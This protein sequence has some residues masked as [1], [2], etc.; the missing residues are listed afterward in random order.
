MLVLIFGSCMSIGAFAESFD[1][2]TFSDIHVNTSTGSKICKTDKICLEKCGKNKKSAQCK[3]CTTCTTATRHIMEINPKGSTRNAGKEHQ[4]DLDKQTWTYFQKLIQDK[5]RTEMP[6]SRFSVV[7]GDLAGHTAYTDKRKEYLVEGFKGL[8][9]LGLPASIFVVGNNDSLDA[10]YG[11][12]RNTYEQTKAAGWA[13]PYLSTGKQC[14]SSPD[15][16][17]CIVEEDSSDYTGYFVTKIAPDLKLI[18]I[19]SV[20]LTSEESKIHHNQGDQATL[21]WLD[22]KVK[23]MGPNETALLAMHI[24]PPRTFLSHNKTKFEKTLAQNSGKIIGIFAGHSHMGNVNSYVITEKGSKKKHIIPIINTPG[25]CSFYGNAP[26]F[27]HVTMTRKNPESPWAIK[28]FS[29]WSIMEDKNGKQRP[30]NLK[31]SKYFSFNASHCPNNPELT[32]GECMT[33]ETNMNSK[34]N[35][36]AKFTAMIRERLTAGNPNYKVP[37]AGHANVYKLQAQ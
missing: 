14:A 34:L 17:P 15:T 19:Y 27:N 18:G 6:N 36:V 26:G 4:N 30:E 37:S 20:P 13:G 25:L 10:D 2:I 3:Q 21:V 24:G 16:Y 22:R 23:E 35:W 5:I 31:L 28:D 12:Y 33:H 11:P 29:T 8:S 1:F 32:L 7:T 9:N